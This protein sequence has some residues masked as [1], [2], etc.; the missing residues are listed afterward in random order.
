[1]VTQIST[2]LVEFKFFR[3]AAQQVTLSGDF[4]QW[5]NNFRLRKDPSGWWRCRLQL[6]PG[7]YQFHYQADGERYIDYAAFGIEPDQAGWNSV[8]VVETE[9]AGTKNL[10]A[11]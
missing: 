8:L 4:N 7:V 9:V 10:E 11:A 6:A 1:M 2:G 3:P 5:Q